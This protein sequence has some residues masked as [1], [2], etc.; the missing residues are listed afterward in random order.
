MNKIYVAIAFG[1]SYEDAWE[2]NVAASK[3]RLKIERYVEDQNARIA[4]LTEIELAVRQ[5]A[6]EY[7]KKNPFDRSTYEAAF[8]VPK[9]PAG[10]D[11]RL[12]TSEMRAE[13]E[14]IKKLNAE[15]AQRNH[16]R[17]TSHN[18]ARNEAINSFAFAHGL[19]Q[20][21]VSNWDEATNFNIIHYLNNATGTKYRV[22]EV[23]E[24]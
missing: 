22:D 6:E 10:M 13:R 4:R 11:Q 21:D 3:D 1:G 12:I 24:I 5:F 15:I 14:S 2:N 19:D 18:E 20:E 8:D 9:W 7:D 16:A 23:D 17:M